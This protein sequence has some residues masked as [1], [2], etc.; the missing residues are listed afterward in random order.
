MR[1]EYK[2]VEVR[3]GLMG[4]KLSG[5]KIEKILNEHAGEG[6]RLRELTPGDVKGRVGPGATEG[7]LLTFERQ[8]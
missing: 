3:E 4:G 2:V 8:V 6:W 7:V 1:Y 5:D